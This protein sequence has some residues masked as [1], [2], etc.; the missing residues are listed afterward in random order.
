[1]NNP[2]YLL[3][4]DDVL[5]SQCTVHCYRASGPGGQ[6]RNKTSSAVRLHHHPTGLLAQA[7]EDRSQHVN[8][9]HALQRLRLKLAIEQLLPISITEYHVSPELAAFLNSFQRRLNMKSVTVLQSLRE[10]LSLFDVLRGVV[11]E[12]AQLTGQST[13]GL[14]KIL[15]ADE[16]VWRVVN[17]IRQKYGLKNLHSND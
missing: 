1:M 10:L 13:A 15:S 9:Q 7:E 8:R 11:H 16:Q 4:E 12:L 6:K 5:L 14:V 3:L 17:H 2:D